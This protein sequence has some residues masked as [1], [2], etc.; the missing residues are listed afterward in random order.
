MVGKG[1]T[2]WTNV[3]KAKPRIKNHYQPHL[4]TD[5]GFYDLRHDDVMIEQALM[6]KKNGIAGFCFYHYWFNGKLVLEKPIESMLKNKK[7]DFPFCLCWA[8]ENWTRNWDGRSKEVLLEQKYSEQDDLLHIEYLAKFLND[9]RAIKVDGKPLLIIY[10]TENL[11]DAKNTV[12]IWRKYCRENGIGEIYLALMEQSVYELDANEIGFDASI[13]F[14]P[15]WKNL[16][17]K[18]RV[19]GDFITKLLHRLKLKESPFIKNGVFSYESY[20]NEIKENTV[21]SNFKRFPGITPMWDNS[22]RRKEGAIIFHDSS[23]TLYGSWLE[24]IVNTFKPFTPE[25]N[26]IF[27]NAWNEWAEGN[28]LEPCVKYENQY[29]K[30]TKEILSKKEVNTAEL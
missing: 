13:E 1:F 12:E 17:E 8:N 11:P 23:P 19:Y 25:E 30:I 6:A 10:K 7:Y 21:H 26:F 20:V 16:S 15:K 22:A 3:T 5:L 4:P 24:H 14:Q 29:L 27:I 18:H 9:K 2:E 28:H